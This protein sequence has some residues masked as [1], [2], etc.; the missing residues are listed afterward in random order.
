[1]GVFLLCHNKMIN[2]NVNGHA[3]DNDICD[4]EGWRADGWYE[5]D[6]SEDLETN[7]D[8]DW[9]YFKN[10]EAKK[11]SYY[12]K[13][14]LTG[15]EL[16][17]DGNTVYRARIKVEGKYFCF[18]EK[19]QMQDGLQYIN[20]DSGFY[21]FDENGY[22]KTGRV[23]SVECDDDDYTFYFNTKNGKNGQGYKGLKDDYLYFNG[24][25]LTADDENR[26]YFYNDKIYLV[27]SKGKIQKGKKGYNIENSSISED[28]VSVEFNSDSSVKSI[29]LDEGK[30]TS[31]TAAQLLAMSL[32]TDSTTS[33]YVDEDG[34]Y[35]DAYVTI[36]FIQLYDNNV[37]T[38]RFIN[39]KDGSFDASEM[40]Y[41]V[42]E[43]ITNRWK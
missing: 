33:D 40:W 26:L 34:R 20:A 14:G 3:D 28:K 27:N 9:Y 12:D 24:K 1:M 8:T 38:Y 2:N 17:D 6:G 13:S 5:I 36:P 43:K 16:T 42:H 18:N 22:Q 7:N 15:P 4:E 32:N 35:D 23:T 39:K 37:Y 11:A 41:D 30:G 31:Y 29:T 10:G 19:G 21:Y 25:K